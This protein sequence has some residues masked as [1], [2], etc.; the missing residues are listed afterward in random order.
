[1][2]K[3]VSG[4]LW[5]V[6]GR[7]RPP[8]VVPDALRPPWAVQKHPGTFLGKTFFR[9]EIMI[10][11]IFHDLHH[12][13]RYFGDFAISVSSSHSLWRSLS[14][15]LRRAYHINEARI[16]RKM[17]G[18]SSSFILVWVWWGLEQARDHSGPIPRRHLDLKKWQFFKNLRE[19]PL[20]FKQLRVRSHMVT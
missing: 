19:S 2:F 18:R 1:M 6:A 9:S 5:T 15:V 17:T 10:S 16:G 7:Y 11:T 13:W 12:F 4:P 20:Y 3:D 14:M 8:G